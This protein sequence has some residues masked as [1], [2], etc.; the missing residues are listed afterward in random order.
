MLSPTGSWTYMAALPVCMSVSSVLNVN[1]M[2]WVLPTSRVMLS[3]DKSKQFL[4]I[5]KWLWKGA[6]DCLYLQVLG[7]LFFFFSFLPCNGNWRS[8]WRSKNRTFHSP[9][10]LTF[11]TDLKRG[12]ISILCCGKLWYHQLSEAK[13]KCEKST[14]EL[15]QLQRNKIPVYSPE[16]EGGREGSICCST[17]Y[18]HRTITGCPFWLHQIRRPAVR[19]SGVRIF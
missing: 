3:L 16:R 4:H 13:W 6:G 12:L 8:Q 18:L 15:A 10:R 9:Y 11:A 14:Q 2:E 19:S 17:V 1:T 7:F 5:H